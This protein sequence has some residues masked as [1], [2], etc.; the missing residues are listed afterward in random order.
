MFWLSLLFL[1]GDNLLILCKGLK[2]M[3]HEEHEG[4][5]KNEQLRIVWDHVIPIQTNI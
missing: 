3:H 2:A 4:K 1:C 5:A